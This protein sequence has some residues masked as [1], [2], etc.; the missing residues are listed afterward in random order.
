[1]HFNNHNSDLL[2][3]SFILKILLFSDAYYLEPSWKP[4]MEFV[5]CK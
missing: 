1:M 4:M 5:Q 2:Q 3:F